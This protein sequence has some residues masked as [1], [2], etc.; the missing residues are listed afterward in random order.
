MERLR[1]RRN[2]NRVI[3]NRNT[4]RKNIKR[5]KRQALI[6]RKITSLISNC[7]ASI[8]DTDILQEEHI[9]IIKDLWLNSTRY[10]YYPVPKKIHNAIRSYTHKHKVQHGESLLAAVINLNNSWS[11]LL[12]AAPPVYQG[13]FSLQMIEDCLRELE[14]RTAI[15][16]PASNQATDLT[17][18]L[19]NSN[20]RLVDA[21]HESNPFFLK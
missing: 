11:P 15:A 7:P 4:R 16:V 17:T 2:A 19:R 13:E 18:A 3:Q 1:V 9:S 5:L 21:V 14:S 6:D 10:D 20:V 12:H 8:L